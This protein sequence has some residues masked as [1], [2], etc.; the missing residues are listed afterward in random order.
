MADAAEPSAARG[1]GEQTKETKP[2]PCVQCGEVKGHRSNCSHKYRSCWTYGMKR[3]K[4]KK[5]RLSDEWSLFVARQP[6]CQR[7]LG[8][9]G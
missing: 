7:D 4:P 8:G 3:E 9:H 5:A 6:S 2:Q 1:K